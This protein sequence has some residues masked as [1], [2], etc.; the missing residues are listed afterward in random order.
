MNFGRKTGFAAEIHGFAAEIHG[1]VAEI[2]GFAAEIH[3]FA[4]EIHGFEAD[5]GPLR[6]PTSHLVKLSLPDIFQ[7]NRAFYNK[8]QFSST[9]NT[10]LI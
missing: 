3:G 1:F 7:D 8:F 10:W 5:S 6:S 2:H 4:A 9:N